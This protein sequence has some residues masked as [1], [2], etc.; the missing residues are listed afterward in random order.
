MIAEKSDQNKHNQRNNTY[1]SVTTNL[2]RQ[3]LS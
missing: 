2:N 1:N 3:G